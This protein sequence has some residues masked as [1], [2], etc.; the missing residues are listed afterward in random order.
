MGYVLRY[1][2]WVH[3]VQM[4]SENKFGLVFKISLRY[5]AKLVSTKWLAQQMRAKN[6]NLRILYASK[7]SGHS[8]QHC[9]IQSAFDF[10]IHPLRDSTHKHMLPSADKFNE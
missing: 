6:A 1:R 3:N 8:F 9:Q 10:C 7:D 5:Y 2:I 4:L